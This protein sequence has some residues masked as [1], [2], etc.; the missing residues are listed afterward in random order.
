M[1]GIL[2][3]P[4][5]SLSVSQPHGLARVHRRVPA[6]VGH[7]HQQRVDPV[8]IAGPGIADH[9]VHHAVRG[10]RV[11]PGVG[12]VD[13]ARLA[14]GI[15]QQVFRRVHEAERRGVERA[16][17]LARLAR[18]VGR[19]NRPRERRLVAERTGRIDRAQQQL[20]HVQRAAG[21]EAVAVRADAAH[22]MHRHRPPG[23]RGVLAAPAVGPRDR[24]LSLLSK[25]AAASS[26]AMRRMVS[27]AMPQRSLTA[28]GEYCGSR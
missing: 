5:A 8:G 10:Q 9:G 22:R 20:Q 1:C 18:A 3:S 7:E 12:V 24:Q 27:A 26:R 15:D 17:V 14:L 19:R 23:H 28:S 4:A 13:A 21:V 2:Y 11:G 16:V 6:H 25:A